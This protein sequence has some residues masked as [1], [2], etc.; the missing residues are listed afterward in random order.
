MFNH[1]L[2]LNSQ[3]AAIYRKLGDFESSEEKL[4]DLIW[5]AEGLGDT[6]RDQVAYFKH[7]LAHLYSDEKW[8]L[9]KVP[10]GGAV[11]PRY[12]VEKILLEA[13]HD[14]AVI[15]NEGPHYLCS[16]EQ[17]RRYYEMTG[18]VHK[19][20]A[21][22]TEKIEPILSAIRPT[23][24]SRIEKYLELMQGAISSF[25]RL[26]EY[27]K[28]DLWLYWRQQQI[29]NLDTK[30]DYSLEALS[31][32]IMHAKTYLDRSM[33]HFAEPL[34]EK[35]QQIASQILPSDHSIHKTIAETINNKAWAYGTCN[36]C[37]VNSPGPILRALSIS[38]SF[39]GC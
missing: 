18:E 7:E 20:S 21:L 31:N 2:G 32:L 24:R 8:R 4:C 26:R 14:F 17:L 35:T 28:A 3:I 19:L 12:R 38:F 22:I 27:E 37:L 9:A 13:I 1:T 34:L 30:G 5:Q 23:D 39:S 15:F 16:L 36:C 29:E 11:P 25:W 6:Y 10:L 33:P